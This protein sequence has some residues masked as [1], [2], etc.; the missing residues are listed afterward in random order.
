MTSIKP[1]DPRAAERL[2]SS[3]HGEAGQAPQPS[4]TTSGTTFREAR[5]GSQPT[6]VS[7]RPEPA[8][9]TPSADAAGA[10]AQAIRAGTMSP[11]QALDR[12][13]ERAVATRSLSEPQRIELRAVLVEALQSDPALRE[14]RD[15]LG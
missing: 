2:G 8:G 5:Q 9:P 13:V 4:G 12:L 14:L 11:E 1:P 7:T 15:A 3:I 10:L 6:Q